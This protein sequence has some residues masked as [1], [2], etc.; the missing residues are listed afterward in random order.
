MVC[1]CVFQKED[2]DNVVGVALNRD[3]V[4]VCAHV[5]QQHALSTAHTLAV[6]QSCT[7]L[8]C[9]SYL[10]LRCLLPAYSTRHGQTAQPHQPC[11]HACSQGVMHSSPATPQS[12]GAE[13][14]ASV[15][16]ERNLTA[17]GPLVLPWGEK[18]KFVAVWLRRCWPG[19]RAKIKAYMPDF[20]KA[21]NHFCLHAGRLLL[22]SLHGPPAHL[23]SGLIACRFK[24]AA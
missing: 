4:K 20:S 9:T 6:C 14:V 10:V 5:H 15:A 13:Q 19:Q 7:E 18:L 1:R 24:P 23:S 21:F 17:L 22:L 12:V 11:W 3:L 16:L 8:L 2:S